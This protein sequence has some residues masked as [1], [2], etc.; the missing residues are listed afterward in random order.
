[1]VGITLSGEISTN[2]MFQ[3]FQYYGTNG[4][5]NTRPPGSEV[6][7]EQYNRTSLALGGVVPINNYNK[8]VG[9]LLLDNSWSDYYGARRNP[10]VLATRVDAWN[11]GGQ[12]YGRRFG[13]AGAGWVNGSIY[14][15]QTAST[16]FYCS[17]AYADY[18][19]GSA[20]TLNLWSASTMYDARSGFLRDIDTGN[21]TVA[22]GGRDRTVVRART[23]ATTFEGTGN[24]TKYEI[25]VF[26]GCK[27]VADQLIT[28]WTPLNLFQ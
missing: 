4:T 3:E 28:D 12:P 5:I 10:V 6:A 21:I 1:M 22:A 11:G 7:M 20:V 25:Q 26:G 2:N 14:V 13:C 18:G 15:R 23:R 19:G 24:P 9:E 27:G 8:N 17:A 16:Y